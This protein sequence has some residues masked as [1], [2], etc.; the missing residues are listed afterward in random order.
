MNKKSS[1]RYVLLLVL[2]PFST[3]AFAELC[4]GPLDRNNFQYPVDIND[5]NDQ[6]KVRVVHRF[7]FSAEVEALIKGIN[8]ELPGDIDYTLMHIPNNYRALHAMG[9]WHI[10]QKRTK[11]QPPENVHYLTPDCY[12][13]R[14]LAFKPKDPLI[15]MLYGIYLHKDERSEEALGMYET[16]HRLNPENAELHYNM[17]LLFFDKRQ[18]ATAREHAD[19]AYAQGYPFQA[20][21]RKLKSVGQ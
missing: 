14:A 8:G 19:K 11:A 5:P 3:T 20:L 12:F 18:Y 6:D 7:H 4:G 21:K 17:G 13:E 1:F 16:A 2:M 15:Y 10:N 9:Q